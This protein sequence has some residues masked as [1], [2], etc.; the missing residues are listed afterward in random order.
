MSS[1][2]ERCFHVYVFY[3]VSVMGKTRPHYPLKSYQ[4]MRQR[5]G[6]LRESHLKSD[7]QRSQLCHMVTI[8]PSSS[9]RIGFY[10]LLNQRQRACTPRVALG[11]S[12]VQY[13]N[14]TVWATAVVIAKTFQ[15]LCLYKLNLERHRFELHWSTY[16]CFVVFS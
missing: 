11:I 2:E 4:V 14:C 5:N 8:R 7:M 12:E 3:P 16:L 10:F 6:W 1:R 15:K 13:L 9:Y